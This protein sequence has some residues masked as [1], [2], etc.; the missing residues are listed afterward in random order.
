MSRC[1]AVR[2]AKKSDARE[3]AAPGVVA[4]RIQWRN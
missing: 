4:C 1:L 2:K 3:C